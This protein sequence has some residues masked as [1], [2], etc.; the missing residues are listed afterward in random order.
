[1]RLDEAR[2]GNI[3]GVAW[4]K[5]TQWARLRERSDD[6]D[7]IERTYLEWSE[8]ASKALVDLRRAG[9]RAV[10]VDIDVEE[11]LAWCQQHDL[12]VNAESRSGYTVRKLREEW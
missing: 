8:C 2:D 9:L 1:M 12:P 7:D 5:P 10:R 6:V 4:Y 11:L 3:V